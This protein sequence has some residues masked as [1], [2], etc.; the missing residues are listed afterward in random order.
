MQGSTAQHS[1]SDDGRTL[2]TEREVV[3]N[4]GIVHNMWA[5]AAGDPKG[6]HVVRVYIE[7]KLIR[8]FE[9]ETE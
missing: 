6:P 5:V 7:G 9:F 3:P 1:V 4:R 8:T 2:T